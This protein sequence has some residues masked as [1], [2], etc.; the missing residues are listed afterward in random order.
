MSEV[1]E[2]KPNLIGLTILEAQS[3][4]AAATAAQ[5]K[6]P[7]PSLDSGGLPSSDR[8]CNHPTDHWL[9]RAASTVAEADGASE[10]SE[11]SQHSDDDDTKL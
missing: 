11:S 2:S 6:P 4:A 5:Q 8:P 7:A 3:Q 1:V 10:N 9:L